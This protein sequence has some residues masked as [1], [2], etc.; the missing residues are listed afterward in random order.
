MDAWIE[1]LINATGLFG[2]A[3]LMF[4]E[5]IVLPIPS[6]VVMPLAGYAAARGDL[7][8]VPTILA[9]T[10]GSIAG[11]A[12]WFSIAKRIGEERLRRWA[13]RFG[14]VLTLTS[15]D[16]DRA[17][18]WFRRSGHIAVF[19]GRLIP[20]IRVLVSIPAGLAGMSWSRFLVFSFLGAL[21]WTGALMLAGYWLG[22]Q[23]GAVSKWVSPVSFAV[24]GVCVT[25]YIVRVVTYP[26]RRRREAERRAGGVVTGPA[27]A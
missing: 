21:L 15:G 24:V 11:A 16:I 12:V 2:V 18:Y 8:I 27:R 3:L 6:E 4:V 19:A 9:G 26:R 1:S 20:A 13:D 10:A 5:N 25:V 7:P 14:R 23:A 17:D 22:N